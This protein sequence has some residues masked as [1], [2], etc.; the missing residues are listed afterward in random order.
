MSFNHSHQVRDISPLDGLSQL[1]ELNLRNTSVTD[2]TSLRGL[3][4]LERLDCA[5]TRITEWHFLQDLRALKT[6]HVSG[7]N[8]SDLT[9]LQPLK[10]L[11]VLECS[12]TE[13]CELGPIAE[14]SNLQRLNYDGT[15]ISDLQPLKAL[16]KLERL[17]IEDC[18]VSDLSPLRGLAALRDLNCSYSGVHDLTP[19]VELSKLEELSA[20][21]CSLDDLPHQLVFGETLDELTLHNTT[22]PGIPPEVLSEQEYDNCLP[23]LRAHLLD[24]AAGSTEIRQTK[25]VVLGNGRVGKTQLCRH[26][27]GLPFDESIPSTHGITVTSEPW[28]AAGGA[29]TLNIWDFGGQDIYHGAHTLFMKTRAIFVVVWRP[30]FEHS[31]EE[32]AD[33]LVFRNYPLSY[34]LEYVRT[35]GRPNSPVIV[36]QS[37]CER[38]EQDVRKLPA[39]DALLDSLYPRQC[40]F[41]AKTGRGK[42]ALKEALEDAMDSLRR[43]EGITTIGTGRLKVLQTLER[44]RDDDQAR[45]VAERQHRTLSQTEFDN[46]CEQAGGVSSSESLL[47]YLHNLGVV[48]HRPD[49]FEDRIILDQSWALDAVYGVF[50]RSQAYP[51]I[52]S[53]AGR[54]NQSLLAMTVWRD[55]GE[56]DQ[57]LFLSLMESCGIIFRHRSAEPRYGTETEYL[58]PD[59]LMDKAAAA[60]QLAGRW[61]ETERSWRLEYEYSF[62]HPGL[63]RALI[64]DVGQRSADAGVYW[65]YGL[66]V[67]ESTGCRAMLE[68][69]MDDLHRG[70]I[71]LKIQGPGHEQLAHWLRERI[72]ARNRFFGYPALQ[73]V[74]DEFKAAEQPHRPGVAHRTVPTNQFQL[75]LGAECE[76]PKGARPLPE[77]NFAQPPATFFPAGEPQVFVSYAWGD[78]TPEGLAR[79]QLVDVLCTK[80]GG[81][82]VKVHRDRDE[83]RPGD[84]ISAF[85]D[86]LAEGDFILAVISD[87][88]LKSENCMYELFNIYRN[89]A[90]KP[91]RFL[92][93]VIPLVLSDAALNSAAT[94][95]T[96]AI[97]WKNERAALEPLI[98]DNLEAA[99]NEIIRKFRLLDEFARNTSDMLELL[100][101]KLQPRDFDRQ[102]AEGFTEILDQ[103]RRKA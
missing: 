29:E 57:R 51:L 5:M 75:E 72:E 76:A 99:G 20:E 63:M 49:L 97:H 26:L 69:R 36:V 90:S 53:Q 58:A 43:L 17:S 60:H 41:S 100:A 31:A 66:W 73:P 35:L 19:L 80:L 91:E 14:L 64:C 85:M 74:V 39:E 25:L 40:A 71:V 22:I 101:D 42:G 70:R 44:W 55:Y 34:W 61:N 21:G 33:G 96:R 48:F 89:C 12:E 1:K 52:L 27:R 87:K 13:I 11:Q 78:R 65:K 8:L 84:R 77:P 3:A 37:R 38:P 81:Q 24:L 28:A 83:L 45:P 93:K 59:L 4:H 88:Y 9:P 10:A 62:L 98:R 30:D 47:A 82:G 56:E 92:G 18:P 86:R 32:T 15:L 67:Y 6:L 16:S 103:I 46:L 2:L 54:F 50:E 7:T 79:G 102:A 68:Q 95:F 94:R 23:T